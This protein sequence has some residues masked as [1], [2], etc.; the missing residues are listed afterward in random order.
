[1]Y[2]HKTLTEK[3]TCI[4]MFMAALFITAT[5][6]KQPVHL[7]MNGYTHRDTLRHKKE[8]NNV[9]CSNT[10]GPRDH[11]TKWSKLGILSCFS[12]VRLFATLWTIAHHAP[13]FMGFSK[14]EYWSGLPFPTAG[15]LP[16]P[17]VGPVSLT[18]P[19]LAGRFFTISIIWE[20]P[21]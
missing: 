10:D 3:Y 19:V 17:G 5:S 1:M 6:W 16:D 12:H 14:Q 21:S 18:F 20:D 9:I 15:D 4:L 8:W 13:L 2:L 7:Q 11:H